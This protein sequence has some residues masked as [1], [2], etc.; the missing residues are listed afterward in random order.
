M[1]N[2]IDGIRNLI[3][4]FPIIWKDRDYDHYYMMEIL[5]K[6]MLFSA[7]SMRESALSN[8]L[9]YAEQMENC[10]ILLHVIQNECYI[11]EAL[12]KEYVTDDELNT[13]ISEHNEARNRLFKLMDEN[14]EKWWH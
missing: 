4:W 13:A 5:K 12:K 3:K 8:S 6:K 10:A 14:I 9:K 11:E 2:L 7:K 1:R